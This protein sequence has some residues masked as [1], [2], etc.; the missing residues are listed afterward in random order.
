MF[1]CTSLHSSPGGNI[2]PTIRDCS[3]KMRGQIS[4]FLPHSLKPPAHPKRAEVPI[5]T[6]KTLAVAWAGEALP[7]LCGVLVFRHHL[8]HRVRRRRHGEGLLPLLLQRVRGWGRPVG[9]RLYGR[10][11]C[12]QS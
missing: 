3:R 11:R 5:N 7:V 2:W 12:W 9:S 1:C 6:C 4:S 8:W 10:G